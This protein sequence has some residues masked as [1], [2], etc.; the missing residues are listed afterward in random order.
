MAPRAG[1]SERFGAHRSRLLYVG[2]DG[3]VS[4][5]GNYDSVPDCARRRVLEVHSLAHEVQIFEDGQLPAVHP[6]LEGRRRSSVLPGHRQLHRI[7][8]HAIDRD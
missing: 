7:I 4:V 5:G 1:S 6:V 3:L 2:H 8:H